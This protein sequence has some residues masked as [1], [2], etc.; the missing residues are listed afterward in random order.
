V[1]NERQHG[2]G[3]KVVLKRVSYWCGFLF[4]IN[5]ITSPAVTKIRRIVST[6]M[7]SIISHL[8]YLEIR[9]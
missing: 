4:L 5:P 8:F 9:V 3:G 2:R 1:S 7:D 6:A